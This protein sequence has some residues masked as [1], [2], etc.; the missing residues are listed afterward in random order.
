ML[1]QPNLNGSSQHVNE[2]RALIYLSPIHILKN[3]SL[4]LNLK[5]RSQYK[6][7]L[8]QHSEHQRCN[9]CI[10][11]HYTYRSLNQ[12]PTT[13]IIDHTVHE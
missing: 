13:Y 2:P 5:L 4:S 11:Q 7:L 8:F 6:Q 12:F 1:V 3:V 9:Q 10:C